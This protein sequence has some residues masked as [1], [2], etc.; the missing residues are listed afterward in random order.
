MAT[1]SPAPANLFGAMTTEMWAKKPEFFMIAKN[2]FRH[3]RF[4]YQ[5]T[6]DQFS[7]RPGYIPSDRF[8]PPGKTDPEFI[9]GLNPKALNTTTQTDEVQLVITLAEY[10]HEFLYL[11]CHIS[12]VDSKGRKHTLNGKLFSGYPIPSQNL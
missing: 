4:D 10:P 3:V 1:N 12:A 8:S 7:R 9:I 11:M 6:F 5:I 2:H